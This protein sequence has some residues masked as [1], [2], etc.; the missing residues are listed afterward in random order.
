MFRGIRVSRTLAV[1]ALGGLL[2][3]AATAVVAFG[4]DG[5]SARYRAH[6]APVAHDPQ[7]DGGS[8]VSGVGRLKLIGKRTLN[9]RVHAEGLTP[10]LPHAM[11][12]HGPEAADEIAR[13]PGADRRDD[14][15]D[16]GLIETAEGID[17]YG[18]VQVSFTTHG[19]TSPDS[20]LALDRFVKARFDG[21]LDYHRRFKVPLSIANR[22]DQLHV[23]LH[24]QDINGDKQYDGPTGALGV[25]IEAEL[26]VACG[27][28]NPRG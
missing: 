28:I 16:D 24:G 11:H 25:P 12:I 21:T 7:A 15:T 2:L 14:I 18:P 10:F 17:D 3:I 1:A 4:A 20:T 13:C 19:D 5:G 22:I 6:L 8:N 9:V 27:G 26:P 23:V